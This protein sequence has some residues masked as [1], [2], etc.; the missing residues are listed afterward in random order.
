MARLNNERTGGRSFRRSIPP[1]PGRGNTLRQRTP[2]WARPAH[3][4]QRWHHEHLPEVRPPDEENNPGAGLAK[5]TG[6]GSGKGQ[7]PITHLTTQAG[8]DNDSSGAQWTT[9][10]N[11]PRLSGPDPHK[12]KQ[13]ISWENLLSKHTPEPGH[14]H[15]WTNHAHRPGRQ[16]PNGPP[17]RRPPPH[18]APP[19]KQ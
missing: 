18:C 7:P 9:P 15:H 11:N 12:T 19:H 8:G 13:P 4:A 6:Y 17:Q 3:A 2:P 14:P 10:T 1:V 16:A 5:T